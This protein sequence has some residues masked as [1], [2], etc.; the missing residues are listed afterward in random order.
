MI[1]SKKKGTRFEREVA[2]LLNK[3]TGGARW[4]RVSNSGAMATA[5]GVEDFRFK[6]D[7]FTE[8]KR[9]ANILIECKMQRKPINLQDIINP[10][11]SWSA[12]IDQTKKE[13]AGMYWL[14]FFRWNAGN[15]M[16]AASKNMPA[17]LFDVPIS[18][19]CSTNE[20]DILSFG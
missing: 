17:L 9:F 12:W 6:G 3:I 13:S 10:K 19:V 5:Q 7:L 2:H 20:Y 4:N 15:I 11:S 8:D 14:M 1:N 18:L 16:F